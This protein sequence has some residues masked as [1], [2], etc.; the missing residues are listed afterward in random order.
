MHNYHHLKSWKLDS[1]NWKFDSLS[2]RLDGWN[3]RLYITSI[4]PLKPSIPNCNFLMFFKIIY[5]AWNLMIGAGFGLGPLYIKGELKFY[6]L[7]LNNTL[8][9]QK[10]KSLLQSCWLEYLI[11]LYHCTKA[12]KETQDFLFS[13]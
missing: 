8:W 5:E 7:I 10:F 9:E 11:L 12:I 2:W 6:V 1:W 4:K 13:L 3:W